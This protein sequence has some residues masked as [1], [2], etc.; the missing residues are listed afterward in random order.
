MNYIYIFLTI[1]ISV[2]ITLIFV[3]PTLPKG[4][5]YILFKLNNEPTAIYITLIASISAFFINKH[6]NENDKKEKNK[7]ID[8]QK[9]DYITM[10]IHELIE[11][12]YKVKF[13]IMDD[14]DNLD[15]FLNNKG[16]DNSIK[17]YFKNENYINYLYNFKTTIFGN[18]FPISTEMLEDVLLIN[19]I[20]NYY[21]QRINIQNEILKVDNTQQYIKFINILLYLANHYKIR[22]D[23]IEKLD[24]LHTNYAKIRNTI[25]Q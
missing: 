12:K 18:N 1:I 13:D 24:E 14:I 6:L 9:Y 15:Y 25:N 5:E 19:S 16:I 23:Y 2:S 8:K 4:I 21:V 7:E 3:L 20:S 17:L 11:I 22:N 10:I